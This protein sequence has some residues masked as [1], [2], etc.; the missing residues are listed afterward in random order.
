LSQIKAAPISLAASFGLVQARRLLT[1]LIHVKAGSAAGA[2]L[3]KIRLAGTFEFDM[4]DTAWHPIATA[5]FDRDLELAV[6]EDGD[7]HALLARCRRLHYGWAN[8]ITGKPMDVN[9][10]HWRYWP[11]RDR[12]GKT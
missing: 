6:V 4:N 11:E 10:T 9:P 7:T 5:P 2:S 8:A 12:Q 3:P 1:Q